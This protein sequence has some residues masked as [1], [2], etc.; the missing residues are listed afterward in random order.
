MDARTLDKDSMDTLNSH[1]STAL[2][3]KAFTS[4][5]SLSYPGGSAEITPPSSEKDGLTANGAVNGNQQD[6]NAL[7]KGVT[8]ATPAAAQGQ[9]SGIVPTLQ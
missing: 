5:T 7:G 3:A 8:P 6:G 4:A 9:S 2:Q 1:P